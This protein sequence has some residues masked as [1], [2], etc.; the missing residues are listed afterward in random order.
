M[1]VAFMGYSLVII[2]SSTPNARQTDTRNKDG[3]PTELQKGRSGLWEGT[4]LG[5]AK[6]PSTVWEAVEAAPQMVYKDT[7][8]MMNSGWGVT[9][10]TS[11]RAAWTLAERRTPCSCRHQGRGLAEKVPLSPPL[12]S[13]VSNP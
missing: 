9:T 13:A 1:A 10:M 5:P 3:D 6:L 4:S 7:Q 11:L 8:H 12:P 2:S